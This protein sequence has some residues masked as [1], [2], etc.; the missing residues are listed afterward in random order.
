MQG[1][2]VSNVNLTGRPNTSTA[3]RG[4]TAILNVIDYA[5]RRSFP[6]ALKRDS[7]A[8]NARAITEWVREVRN[9]YYG[10]EDSDEWPIGRDMI[11]TM[12]N[13]RTLGNQ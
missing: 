9:L 13:A 10:D 4:K 12:D 6:Y 1:G 11:V 3:D 8:E 7:G 2:S 5:T